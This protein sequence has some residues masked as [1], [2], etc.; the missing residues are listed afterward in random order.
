M[1]E[2]RMTKRS[3]GAIGEEEEEKVEPN[4]RA[5]GETPMVG[6]RFPSGVGRKFIPAN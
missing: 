3:R 4:Q 1:T 6:R 5:K 2:V